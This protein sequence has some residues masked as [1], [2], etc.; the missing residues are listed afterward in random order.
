MNLAGGGYLPGCEFPFVVWYGGVA[1]FTTREVR[2]DRG[3]W[4]AVVF[5]S[6]GDGFVISRVPRG[7]CTPSGHIEH[8]E[9]PEAR[10]YREVY[11]EIGA[12]IK[13]LRRIGSFATVSRSGKVECAAVFHARLDARV[14]LPEGTE[15]TDVMTATIEQLP[16]VYWHWD[17][18]MQRMFQHAQSIARDV[19]GQE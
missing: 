15:A 6:D 5:V 10:A 11:E 17:A 16:A 12:T 2:C 3:V 18:L 13:D 9:T 7:W 19:S 8:G 14:G 1:T 4:A